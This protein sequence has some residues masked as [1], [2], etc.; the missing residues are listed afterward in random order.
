MPCILP[1]IQIGI[2]QYYTNTHLVL[3]LVIQ[4]EAPRFCP[5]CF[6]KSKSYLSVNTLPGAKPVFLVSELYNICNRMCAAK[7]SYDIQALK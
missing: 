5:M 2:K 1:P 6:R 4:K 3:S 7:Y